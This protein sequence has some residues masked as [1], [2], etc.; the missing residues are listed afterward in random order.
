MK[1]RITLL[2]L[3]CYTSLSA[4]IPQSLNDK[5]NQTYDSLC[6]KLNIKGSS[7]AIIIPN[8]GTWKRNF[9][10][11]YIG[12][13]TDTEMLFT[14]G[15]N[16]K[17]YTATVI[18]KLH[19]MGLLNLNDTIGKWFNNVKNVKGSIKIQQLLNHTSGIASYTDNSDLWAAVN[20]D[21]GKNWAME[22]I[23]PY[24]G[25]PTFAPGTNW[26]YSNSNF[27]LAGIIIK[28]VTGKT[29]AE[30][31]RSYIFTP[32]NLSKTFL[33]A[34]ESTTLD[35]AHHWSVSI[36]NTYLTD[37]ESLG[38]SYI[39]M[40]SVANSAGGLYATAEDNA[41]FFNA[42]FNTKI[43]VADSM[44]SKMKTV[45][46]IGNGAGYGLGLFS[47]SN[48]NGRTVY[49]HGG[50]NLGGINENLF[51]PVNNCS[52]SVL[53]NQD[54]VSN[55]L[56]L[57]QVVLNLHKQ[58]ISAKAGIEDLAIESSDYFEVYPNPSNGKFSINYKGLHDDK[59]EQVVLTDMNGKSIQ[60][61]SDIDSIIELQS[62][63]NGIYFLSVKLS[64][65]KT[66]SKKL[67]LINE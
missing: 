19:Q 15:S 61:I 8:M 18:L 34:D 10:I 29:L 37:W 58:L 27:L 21:L 7:A 57:T 1:I 40:N 11:S 45:R 35:V 63:Q 47:Y 14:L 9:G 67:V 12:K 41:K 62:K 6:T 25:T 36:G 2:F 30:A 65:G 49:S 22:D 24:I 44:L 66:I 26:A 42:L 56:L 28:Q 32:C 54:S 64:S 59:I 16:T 48:F 46:N 39:A 38:L 3:V 43:I 13:S 31:Y 60:E 53:S 51:D 33:L 23:L 50:T 20:T 52:I 4:Q 55:N 5:L 17:T